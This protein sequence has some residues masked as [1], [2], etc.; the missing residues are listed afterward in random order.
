MKKN[1]TFRPG[2]EAG[3]S[4]RSLLGIDAIAPHPRKRGYTDGEIPTWSGACQGLDPQSGFFSGGP[5]K[6][7]DWHSGMWFDQHPPKGIE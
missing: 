6:T 4:I 3:R 7:L 1:T 5:E 2:L